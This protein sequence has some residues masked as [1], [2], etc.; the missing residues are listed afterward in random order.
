MIL[1]MDDPEI[2]KTIQALT[3]PGLYR[4]VRVVRGRQVYGLYE[5]K[6]AYPNLSRK[7]PKRQPFN[8]NQ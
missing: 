7:H 5:K 6:A 2:Y 8:L 4:T 3:K 1:N